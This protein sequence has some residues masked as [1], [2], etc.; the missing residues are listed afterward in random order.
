MT[1]R[2]E[3]TL[4]LMRQGGQIASSALKAVLDNTRV[5]ASALE[6]NA[7]AEKEIGQKGAQPSFK[8]VPGYKFATCINFNEQVVHGLPTERQIKDGDIISVDLGVLYQGWHTDVAW[9]ILVGED[10]NKERFLRVGKEALWL[11]IKQATAGNR[12]G[13][14]SSAIGQE[15]GRAGFSIVK[16]LVGHGVGRRL[17]EDP[18][19]PGF[20]R[21]GTGAYLR[22]GMTLAIEVIYAQGLGGVVIEDD[23][24]TVS[25]TDRSLSAVFELTVAVKEG[26]AEVLTPLMWE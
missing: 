25:T 8:T 19:V 7:S 22:S 14:I 24:W 5:G 2:D 1:P 21:A 23:G 15:I 13:D 11:G 26:K 18:E 16:S 10:Q 3:E 20:G 4:S 9:T 12:V 17:H 6:L